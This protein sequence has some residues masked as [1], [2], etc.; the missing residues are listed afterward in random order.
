MNNL[1][2]ELAGI[3]DHT[4]LHPYVSGSDIEGLCKEATDY[5][6][7]SV[8]VH[9]CWTQLA[10]SFLENSDVQVCTVVGFPLGT[11]DPDVKRYETEVAID[12]GAQEIDVVINIGQLKAGNHTYV[13]REL[14]DVVE[15][16]DERKVKVIIETCYLS[17]SEKETAC[18]IVNDSGAHFVKTSTGFGKAGATTDDVALMSK[19]V[20]QKLGVKASGG[21]RTTQQAL[22]M[23]KAGAT[24]LGLSSSVQIV[25]GMSDPDIQAWLQQLAFWKKHEQVKKEESQSEDSS[26][27]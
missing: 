8:C 13:H 15:A 9:G 1:S 11:Q 3:I 5:G 18:K 10:S 25:Q 24:R 27:Y 14:R 22:E 21:I 6:F 12:E 20:G 7:F 17:Q 16:A 2:S 23:I 4:L 19:L 26:G